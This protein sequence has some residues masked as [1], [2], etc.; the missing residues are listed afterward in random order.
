MAHA[1]KLHN[2]VNTAYHKAKHKTDSEIFLAELVYLN[3]LVATLLLKQVSTGIVNILY[4]ILI[5]VGQTR[6]KPYNI[7]PKALK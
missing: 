3:C 6:F 4:T 1:K 5:V 7:P 2:Q